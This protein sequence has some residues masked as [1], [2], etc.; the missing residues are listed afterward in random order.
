KPIEPQQLF[1]A[2]LKW[3][4]PGDR[5]IS[6]LKIPTEVKE[7]AN[8]LPEIIS[9]IDLN[10]GL[11]RVGGNQKLY[12]DLLIKFHRDNQDITEQIQKALKEK[13]YE[14]AQRLAHTV[15]GVAGN[16][17]AKEIQ[18]AAEVVELA[19]KNNQLDTINEMIQTLKE[20]LT[21]PITELNI[22][23]NALKNED[24]VKAEKPEGTIDQ[25]KTFLAELEPILKKRKPKPCKEVLE[26]VNEFEW[27]EEYVTLLDDLSKFVSKYKFK[28]ASKTLEELK[29][30]LSS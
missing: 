14:L 6:Q 5:D 29:N 11:S 17:G 21:V 7:A 2:L 19:I 9:G 28:E 8:L 26:K 1:S 4:K 27:P 22:L 30:L 12:R 10:L 23:V 18:K 24:S 20:N 25:L 16:I 3:I 15:K 13:D